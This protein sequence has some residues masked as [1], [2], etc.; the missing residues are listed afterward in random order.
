MVRLA[1]LT[2]YDGT[3]YRGWTDVRDSSLRP[4]LG[5]VLGGIAEPLLEAASRTDAG[6]HALGNVATLTLDGEVNAAHNVGQLQYSL[7]QLLP[8]EVAV[9]RV[10]R[11]AESFDVRSNVGKTYVYKFSTS[12]CRDPLSRLYEWHVPQRRGQPLWNSERAAYLAE[13]LCGTHSFSAFANTPRGRERHSSIDPVCTLHELSLAPT[14]EVDSRWAFTVRGD[15]FLY[16]MVRNL[17]GALVRVGA[18]DSLSSDEVLEALDRGVF[19]R[20]A[21]MPLTAPAHGLVLEHV[22]YEDGDAPF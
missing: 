2:S 3:P 4:A 17:V 19:A 9:R 10:A 15:R 11:V 8:P 12:D 5:R 21:S 14:S 22:H 7:N 6:V 16:K 1:L 20:S 18:G 13:R